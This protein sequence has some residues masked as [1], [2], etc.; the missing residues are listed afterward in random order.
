MFSIFLFVGFMASRLLPGRQPDFFMELPPLRLPQLSNVL[1]KTYTRVVWYFKEVFPLFIIASVVIW[2]L[3][4]TGIFSMI[5]NGL[6]PV[7]RLLGLPAESTDVFLFGFFRRDYGAAGLFDMQ[8]MLS[9]QQI[10]VAAVTLTLFVPCVAHLMVMIKERGTMAAMGI[11][12]FVLA[13]AIGTGALLNQFL[14]FVM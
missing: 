12:A 6:E 1:S 8:S 5:L 13:F 4:I 11:F 10:T 14:N 7:V 2:V 9:V 3:Q